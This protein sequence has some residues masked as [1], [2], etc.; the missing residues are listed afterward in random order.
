MSSRR[1][2]WRR[3]FNREG[4]PSWTVR[5][6]HGQGRQDGNR[7]GHTAPARWRRRR[8]S[9]REAATQPPL[10]F[11]N[12]RIHGA[13]FESSAGGAPAYFGTRIRKVSSCV[14][15]D[16]ALRRKAAA[17]STRSFHS[18]PVP[19]ACTLRRRER[20]LKRCFGRVTSE[21]LVNNHP[22]SFHRSKRHRFDGLIVAGDASRLRERSRTDGL[23]QRHGL[24]CGLARGAGTSL[25]HPGLAP[26]AATAP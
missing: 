2:L 5:S 16:S 21:R 20:Y 18:A 12:A 19:E 9:S 13:S 17:R 25:G 8:R 26:S 23:Q 14:P 6:G 24:R 7:L 11:C 4:G 22:R 3:S 1:A 10:G 15:F